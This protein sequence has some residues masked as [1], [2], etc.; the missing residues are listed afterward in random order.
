[1]NDHIHE[2]DFYEDDEA[3]NDI[4][5]AWNRSIEG[6]VTASP[7]ALVQVMGAID[8]PLIAPLFP[9]VMNAPSIATIPR[10]ENDNLLFVN[11]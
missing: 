3:T 2:G 7:E 10:E 11:A 8:L 5:V 4:V 1:M 6:G 9:P